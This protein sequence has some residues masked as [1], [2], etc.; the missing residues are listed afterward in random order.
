MTMEKLNKLAE[1]RGLR[2][3]KN[4]FTKGRYYLVDNRINAVVSGS[5][6]AVEIEDYLKNDNY[7]LQEGE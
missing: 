4:R 3:F 7:F 6:P 5:M 1:K 2:V